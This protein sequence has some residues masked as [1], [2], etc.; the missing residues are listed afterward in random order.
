MAS[1]RT[2]IKYFLY[3]HPL[4]KKCLR[5]LCIAVCPCSICRLVHFGRRKCVPGPDR[6]KRARMS[7]VRFEH[8]LQ[9]ISKRKSSLSMSAKST[10]LYTRLFK[11]KPSYQPQSAFFVKLPLEIRTI[12]LEL[13][14]DTGPLH[15]AIQPRGRQ[16]NKFLDLCSFPCVITDHAIPE[17]RCRHG[18]PSRYPKG[19][20]IHRTMSVSVLSTCRLMYSEATPILYNT[21]EFIF[22]SAPTFAVFTALTPTPNL[23][24]IRHIKFDGILEHDF[25]I[26]EWYRLQAK[27]NSD[28]PTTVASGVRSMVGLQSISVTFKAPE[29]SPR[30]AEVAEREFEK[31]LEAMPRS[32]R[33]YLFV[34]VMELG[35]EILKITKDDGSRKR[36]G[37]GRLPLVGTHLLPQDPENSSTGGLP[38]GSLLQTSEDRDIEM[39]WACSELAAW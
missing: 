8:K 39:C 18:I 25:P 33:L 31:V 3:C 6:Y 4:V 9:S 23:E 16:G 27:N 1:I 20:T 13:V 10:S 21:K 37:L 34:E 29:D 11:P 2:E 15:I 5:V 38:W 28:F 7:E 17:H 26:D 14:L 22:A 36:I 30:S 19:V 12:I 35:W 32:C 24:H